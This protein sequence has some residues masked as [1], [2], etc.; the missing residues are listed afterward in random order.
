MDAVD[1]RVDGE[2]LEPVSLRLDHRGI[3]T[4]ADEQPGGLGH[5]PRFDAADELPL[6]EV[7]NRHFA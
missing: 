3:V 5:E 7:R 6:G 1:H 4:D 2:H